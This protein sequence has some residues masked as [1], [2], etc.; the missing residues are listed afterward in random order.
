[1]WF[2][3][4]SI[5]RIKFESIFEILMMLAHLW[6]L[7]QSANLRLVC[8]Y[9]REHT[10]VFV[11]FIWNV[12][13]HDAACVR[14]ACLISRNFDFSQ[15][16]G[17]QMVITKCNARD[18]TNSHFEL[19]FYV[20]RSENYPIQIGH[21]FQIPNENAPFTPHFIFIKCFFLRCRYVVYAIYISSVFDTFINFNFYSFHWHFS[22]SFHLCSLLSF[23]YAMLFLYTIHFTCNDFRFTS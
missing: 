18:K 7:Y 20:L 9:K 21:L 2:W 23:T 5:Q 22:C 12:S 17:I 15:L 3:K 4:L 10:T 16:N 13:V 11:V 14:I 1:M 6:W 19:E 8:I